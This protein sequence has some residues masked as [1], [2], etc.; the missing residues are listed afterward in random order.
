MSPV[1]NSVTPNLFDLSPFTLTFIKNVSK[2]LKQTTFKS[3][4]LAWQSK[5]F[6]L[7]TNVDQ[8]LLETY[9]SIAICRR[10]TEH[11]DVFSTVTTNTVAHGNKPFGARYML[12]FYVQDFILRVMFCLPVSLS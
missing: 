11:N 3:R 5:K 8:N 7:S 2:Y 4:D 9:F 12:I 6:I 10:I 1:I